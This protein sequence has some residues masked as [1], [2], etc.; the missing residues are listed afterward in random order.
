MHPRLITLPCISYETPLP[1]SVPTLKNVNIT[2]S[3]GI[4]TVST[5]SEEEVCSSSVETSEFSTAEHA[6]RNF[7]DYA[8]N[9]FT[10][11]LYKK[12]DVYN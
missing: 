3:G 9:F 11:Y 8:M 2:C 6:Q 5:K 7:S 1:K 4:T 10:I 12:P